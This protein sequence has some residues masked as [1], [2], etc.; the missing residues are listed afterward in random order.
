M[1]N[2]FK[3]VGIAKTLEAINATI[4]TGTRIEWPVFRGWVTTPTGSSQLIDRL[5]GSPCQ[6]TMTRSGRIVRTSWRIKALG[7]P[8]NGP[9]VGRLREADNFLCRSSST[10]QMIQPQKRLRHPDQLFFALCKE[11]QGGALSRNILTLKK[12][13]TH[14]RVF[15]NGECP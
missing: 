13:P 10:L 14:G 1:T 5:I 2:A 3:S 15:L 8:D 6:R 4:G 12:Y 9:A 7:Q 11:K